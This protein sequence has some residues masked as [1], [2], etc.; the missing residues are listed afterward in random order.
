MSKK[1]TCAGCL[2]EY[3]RTK[4]TEYRKKMWCGEEICREVIDEKVKHK[5]YRRKEKKIANGT[6]RSGIEQEK[7]TA[8]LERDQNKCSRCRKVSCDFGAM[9]VHHIIP[10]SEGGAD[11]YD[12]LIT[13]C[14]LCHT[15][16]HQIGWEEYVEPFQK[17]VINLEKDYQ[18]Q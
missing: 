11:E 13:L 17:I 16:V 7:R 9:Q 8:I 18:A 3:P 10:V 15:K 6:W 14:T 2:N 1:L 5:N 4:F 12:N